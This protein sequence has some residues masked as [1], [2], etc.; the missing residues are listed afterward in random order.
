MSK[1]IIEVEND[2]ELQTIETEQLREFVTRLGF[3]VTNIEH[4]IEELN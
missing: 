2:I 1:I 4:E 3:R